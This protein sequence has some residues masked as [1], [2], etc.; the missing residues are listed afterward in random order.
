MGSFLYKSR[1]GAKFLDFSYIADKNSMLSIKRKIASTSILENVLPSTT[2]SDHFDRYRKNIVLNLPRYLIRPCPSYF[3]TNGFYRPVSSVAT[4][5]LSL[6]EVGGSFLGPVKSDSVASNSP[7]LL[8]IFGVRSYVAQA[9]SRGAPAL[10]TRFGVGYNTESINKDL[11]FLVNGF[12][13]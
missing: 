9:L 4:T 3:Q 12:Y 13:L 8:C 5:L 11:I 1:I 7:P 6:R 10:V 2:I